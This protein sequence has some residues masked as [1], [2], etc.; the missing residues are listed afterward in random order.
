[1]NE[2]YLDVYK[3]ARCV[4]YNEDLKIKLDTFKAAIINGFD[5]SDFN[6]DAFNYHV[7]TSG[8][9]ILNIPIFECFIEFHHSLKVTNGNP[10]FKI[11]AKE[12][13]ASEEKE[14][15]TLFLDRSGFVYFEEIDQNKRFEYNSQDIFLDV[16]DAV[17]K[18]LSVK[19]RISY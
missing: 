8:N 4:Q 17:I 13:D 3:L 14:I 1:M 7:N 19:G 11:V 10:C 9:L 5:E 12:I 16:L 2:K 6:K 18:K 15:L